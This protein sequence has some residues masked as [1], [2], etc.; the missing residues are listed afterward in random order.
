M[1]HS[2][3]DAYGAPNERLRKLGQRRRTFQRKGSGPSGARATAGRGGGVVGQYVRQSQGTIAQRG[4]GGGSSYTGGEPGDLRSRI[5]A[6]MESSGR[7]EKRR[8]GPGPTGERATAGRGG[9][10]MARQVAQMRSE[11]A[12]IPAGEGGD[13][14]YPEIPRSIEEGI[15]D[16]YSQSRSSRGLTRLPSNAGRLAREL[17]EYV[18]NL[19]GD[20]DNMGSVEGTIATVLA[21]AARA[22]EAQG[23]TNN[24]ARLSQIAEQWVAKLKA[25]RSGNLSGYAVHRAYRARGGDGITVSM[26]FVHA[27]GTPMTD[28]GFSS[29]SSS[30]PS[31]SSFRPTPLRQ[32]MERQKELRARRKWIQDNLRRRTSGAP[33]APYAVRGSGRQRYQRELQQVESKLAKLKAKKASI[34]RARRA[35]KSDYAGLGDLKDVAM[36]S[37]HIVRIGGLAALYGLATAKDAQSS[38]G[39]MRGIGF[40]LAGVVAV[41]VGGT[42]LGVGDDSA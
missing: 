39:I 7:A 10:E 17:G 31:T 16:Y 4:G 6:Y 11:A 22:A 32:V 36:R 14:D 18:A 41:L 15:P 19:P 12:S 38:A 37:P 1:D 3:M 27:R 24:A 8:S 23:D 30:G 2:T 42:L 21:E 40:G 5:K 33:G 29:A 26:P 9:G 28:Y 20:P 13:Y 34:L 35:R 25:E